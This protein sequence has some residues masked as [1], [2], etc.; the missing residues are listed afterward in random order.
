M[1]ETP[2]F[3]R[4]EVDRFQPD[5]WDRAYLLSPLTYMER[6]AYR[7][8]LAR[9]AGAMPDNAVMLA[10]IRAAIRE[11]GAANEAEL[12]AAVETAEELPDDPDAQARLSAI[13]AAVSIMPV[14]AAQRALREQVV[15]M[16]PF[17]AARHALRGWDGPGLPAFRR[18]RGL[19]PDDL[20]E[21]LPDDELVLIGWR[22][23]ALMQPAA[24][25]EKN[26]EAPSP[27]PET[28]ETS[29]AA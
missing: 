9:S 22:A 17:I 8:D 25:A 1:S 27:S 24:S 23:H 29:P 4:R 3:S 15:G 11:L 2:V 18:V 13:E 14:Y 12:L 16:L 26:S 10:A 20:L 5:G 7:A 19:V 21:L 6:Q 28:P